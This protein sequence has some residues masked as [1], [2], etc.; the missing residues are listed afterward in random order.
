MIGSVRI[1][2]ADGFNYDYSYMNFLSFAFVTQLERAQTIN[3]E[4]CSSP[5]RSWV[6]F[7]VATY[8]KEILSAEHK[9]ELW[10]IEFVS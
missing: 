4:C 9:T 6:R 1:L 2:E 3:L 7:P 5:C 10:V 8:V